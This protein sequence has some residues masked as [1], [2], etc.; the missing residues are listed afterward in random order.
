[1]KNLNIKSLFSKALLL[2]LW[3][4]T[5]SGGSTFYV[6]TS[7]KDDYPGTLTQPFASIQNAQ[8]K[9]N[10]GDTLLIRGG[11][12][13]PVVPDIA[14]GGIFLYKS[15]TSDTQRI[16]YW[17]YPGETPVFDFSNLKIRDGDYTHGFVVS[18]SW[19]HLK[20]LEIC[21]VPMNT[22]S[23]VGMFV[24]ESSNNIFELMNFHHNNGS[25]TFVNDTKGGGGH[26]YLNCDSHDNYDPTSNQG[27]GQNADG[28]GYH[29]Q[30]SGKISIYRGCRA[31]W[32]SDDGWDFISQEVPVIIENS[33][34]M[35]N[36]LAKYGT[37][38]PSSGNGNGFKAGSSKTG[39]RHII[40]NSVAWKNRASGFYAN[41]S[42]GGN[43]WINNTSYAN[44]T[45]FNLWASTWDAEGN[46]TD[47]IILTGTKAHYMRNNIGYPNNNK[48]M[49]GVN[50]SHNTWDLNITPKESDF[51]SLSDPS[52]TTTGVDLSSIPG[53]LGPRQP[54]GDL[55][56]IDFLKLSENSQM[57]DKGIDV[58]FPTINAPDLGAYEFG[59]G[60]KK[61]EISKNASPG[62]MII[63]DPEG[64]S[65]SEGSNMIFTAVPLNG[66]EFS[67]WSGDYTGSDNPYTIASL[68]KNV[69]LEA[70]FKFIGIDSTL[71]EG[72]NTKYTNAVVES[73]HLGFS[74]DGY[75]NFNNVIGS[76][77]EFDVVVTEAGE[78]TLTI[79][80]SNGAM[81]E[82]PVSISVNGKVVVE[83]FG[84]TPTDTWDTWA[85]HDLKVLLEAGVN[86]IVMTSVTENG[87]PNLDLLEIKNVQSISIKNNTQN[88]LNKASYNSHSNSISLIGSHINIQLFSINGIKYFDFT[89]SF[90]EQKTE[91]QLPIHQLKKGLYL[92][93]I[94]EA[95]QI[96]FIKIFKN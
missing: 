3:I 54:N 25:G 13:K 57:I 48:Y 20:G 44:G 27:E 61:F 2:C 55:P 36:G 16:Y 60:S 50:T 87:G 35:G 69:N 30:T 7:G 37:Y 43:D 78:K 92:L 42:S 34:A 9:M 84:Y 80:Y 28:F 14:D 85:T 59:M 8:E 66:W 83:S 4:Y 74:G 39:I 86:T 24:R 10:P 70:N 11:V 64:T 90:S 94:K 45:S 89:T 33:F 67:G 53:A 31:W 1:M 38:K 40:R 65:L 22:K 63:Q 79:T 93:K 19:L 73:E 95:N 49:E 29:Y 52:M 88:N 41:H 5:L 51:L 47:G 6:S 96:R 12:Y 23:N 91:I 58:G 18:G 75:I 81:D 62:G 82:R 72:E 46:R 68:N 32:N 17:A 26:L 77:V 71:Y 21:N 56:S 76:T 15:G